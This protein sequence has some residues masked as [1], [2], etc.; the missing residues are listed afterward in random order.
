MAPRF[1]SKLKSRVG[2][3]TS[4]T[5]HED[6]DLSRMPAT[7]VAH[8]PTQ[9]DAASLPTSELEVPAHDDSQ[10]S[11]SSLQ[12]QLWNQ[13]YDELKMT[14]PKLTDMYETVLSNVLSLNDSAGNL[15]GKTPDTRSQQMRQLVQHELD[16]TERTAR[17]KQRVGEGLEI[18]QVV[19]GVIDKA[20]QAAP[21]AA[22][23][24]AGVC[25]GLEVR[26]QCFLGS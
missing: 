25:L 4:R 14:E 24:W 21:Q 13:A 12:E 16:R 19:R 23:A 26:I 5:A 1:L 7:E 17:F 8:S 22:V 10:M 3:Q 15:I 2:L 20:I 11:L 6:S 9:V 18:V